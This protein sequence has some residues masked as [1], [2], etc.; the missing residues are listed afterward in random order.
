[1]GNYEKIEDENKR[2]KDKLR[3]LKDQSHRDN[4]SFDGFREYENESW[5]DKEEVLNYFLFEHLDLRNIKIEHAHR[6]REKRQDT[7]RTIVAKFSS[8]K[9]KEMI[10]KNA[11]KL[12]GTCYYINEDFSKE[13]VEIRKENWKK[14]KELK[15]MV[16]ML[17]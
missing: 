6:A 5:N 17:Y 8:Y 16:N 10:L 7:S 12:K 11:R 2:L 1:M 14:V 13:N 4:L 9:T 3:G 15:K